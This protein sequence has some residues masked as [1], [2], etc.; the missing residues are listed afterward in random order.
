MTVYVGDVI[1]GIAT[2]QTIIE[3]LGAL[4]GASQSGL[5]HAASSARTLTRAIDSA[6]ASVDANIPSDDALGLAGGISG[7]FGPDMAAELVAQ[8]DLVEQ[9][10]TLLDLRAYSGRVA[11]N[12]GVRG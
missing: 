1:E 9:G 2:L 6:M 5:L 12:L 7:A 11:I 10:V 8:R 3:D 4:E